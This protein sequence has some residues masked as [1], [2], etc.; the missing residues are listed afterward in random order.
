M[1]K[2]LRFKT[3]VVKFPRENTA[4]KMLYFYLKP[5]P[6]PTRNPTPPSLNT[7]F[8]RE[9]SGC[10]VPLQLR[11][12]FLGALHCV[13]I[14]ELICILANLYWLD[15]SSFSHQGSFTRCTIVV[16]DC[17]FSCIRLTNQRFLDVLQLNSER[18][19]RRN[20]T[21]RQHNIPRDENHVKIVPCK[22]TLEDESRPKNIRVGTYVRI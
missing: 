15:E 10:R 6:P 12:E 3:L 1:L 22:W 19:Q 7:T 5:P 21:F 2:Q 16:Y 8:K 11:N 9:F 14:L 17:S 4:H 13:V 18:I 20:C